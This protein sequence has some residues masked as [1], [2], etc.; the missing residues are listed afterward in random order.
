MAQSAFDLM[1]FTTSLSAQM[2]DITQAEY[3][4]RQ[5]WMLNNLN[6][7]EL[8]VKATKI[9]DSASYALAMGIKGALC[10]LSCYTFNSKHPLNDKVWELEHI[11][12]QKMF[13]WVLKNLAP[14]DENLMIRYLLWNKRY[15]D[16]GVMRK[17]FIDHLID[18]GYISYSPSDK[19][20]FEGFVLTGIYCKVG[21]NVFTQDYHGRHH[22][23]YVNVC[24]QQYF[25]FHWPQDL[26]YLKTIAESVPRLEEAQETTSLGDGKGAARHPKITRSDLNRIFKL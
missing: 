16:D 13:K 17:K 12:G 9:N 10:S 24:A 23:Q 2:A 14:K 8:T 4:T 6:F 20:G 3:V 21:D 5:N 26:E 18:K 15:T 22:R 19:Y 25:D 11:L 1:D 7:L